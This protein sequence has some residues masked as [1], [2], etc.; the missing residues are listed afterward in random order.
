MRQWYKKRDFNFFSLSL[1]RLEFLLRENDK[2]KQ[3]FSWLESR[4][5]ETWRGVDEGKCRIIWGKMNFLWSQRVSVKNYIKF[6]L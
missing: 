5:R 3:D 6:I 1:T 4:V 2:E